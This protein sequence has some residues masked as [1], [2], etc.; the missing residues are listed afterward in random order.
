M[1]K[2]I[3]VI[4]SFTLSLLLSLPPAPQPLISFIPFQ[5]K[6]DKEGEEKEEKHFEHLEENLTFV[7]EGWV[8]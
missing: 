1:W 5:P 2:G 3:K 8:T 4:R 7:M 6:P